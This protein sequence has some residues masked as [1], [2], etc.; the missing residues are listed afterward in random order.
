MSSASFSTKTTCR[1]ESFQKPGQEQIYLIN[2]ERSEDHET[3]QKVK[4]NKFYGENSIRD[5]SSS[6]TSENRTLL[7]AGA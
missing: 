2:F 4:F 3:L 1:S 5:W 7:P 6:E